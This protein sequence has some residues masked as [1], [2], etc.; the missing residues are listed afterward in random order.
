MALTNFNIPSMANTRMVTT[1]TG[2]YVLPVKDK[3]TKR[4]KRNKNYKRPTSSSA[5]PADYHRV[6]DKIRN[7]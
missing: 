3:K 7:S 5:V 6:L 4:K 2:T 1:K